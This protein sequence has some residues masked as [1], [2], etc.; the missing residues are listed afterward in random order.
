M[1]IKFVLGASGD[2]EKSD[3]AVSSIIS[4]RSEDNNID[5]F[6]DHFVKVFAAK[7]VPFMIKSRGS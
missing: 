5:S 4:A 2:E 7:P 6:E 3:A 1:K